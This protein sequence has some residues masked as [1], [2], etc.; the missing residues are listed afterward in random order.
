MNSNLQS[1]FIFLSQI[2]GVP[3]IDSATNKTIGY[4]VDV[5]AVLREMYPRV[6]A[7]IVREK[8]SSKRFYLPWKNIQKVF[9]QRAIFIENVPP[10][11][12]RSVA[13]A[14]NEILLKETFLDK[15]VV[16]I[17]GSKVVR[18]NDLHFLRENQNLWLVH[19][20]V[21]FKGLLRRLG[22]QRVVE[23]V[24]HWLFSYAFKDRFISWK[25][26]QSV[27]P[28]RAESLA[29]KV[30]QTKLAELHP[31]DLADI[32]GDLGTDERI[33]ILKSLDKT[34]A[35]EALKELPLK[36]R[37]QTAELLDQSQLVAIVNEM[38]I[39]EAVDLLGEFP[40]K[41]L[42]SLFSIIPQDRVEQI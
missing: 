5:V 21:G 7:L 9:D 37:V 39:D 3:V 38:P 1:N 17:S 10:P 23:P 25:Y 35:A 29:L 28:S 13:L 4:A 34:T 24:L 40:R 19:M 32:L 20:D 11:A 42:N 26:V 14:E 36:A 30:P 16:D 8:M 33:M 2:L 27:T 15:Q 41:R 31:A 22:W 6:S 12:E 18:V